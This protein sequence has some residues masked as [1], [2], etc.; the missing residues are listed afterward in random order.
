MQSLC[1]DCRW[2]PACV[3]TYT[4]TAAQGLGAVELVGISDTLSNTVTLEEHQIG[5]WESLHIWRRQLMKPHRL[6]A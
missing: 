6:K 2:L 1:Q 3:V 5:I 4:V